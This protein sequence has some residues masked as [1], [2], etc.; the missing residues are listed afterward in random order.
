MPDKWVDM[1]PSESEAARADVIAEFHHTSNH[2]RSHIAL[3]DHRPLC[4][5]NDLLDHFGEASSIA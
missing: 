1:R 3:E 2:Q 5:V 4:H